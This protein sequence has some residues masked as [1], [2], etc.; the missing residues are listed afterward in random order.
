ML[1]QTGMSQERMIRLTKK[2]ILSD[3]EDQSEPDGH[4][5]DRI[6]A[7]RKDP[8]K[9]LRL[10]QAQLMYQRSAVYAYCFYS[11]RQLII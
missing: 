4:S 5:K 11:A 7:D 8:I 2:M 9:G 6:D 1:L 3:E 10:K